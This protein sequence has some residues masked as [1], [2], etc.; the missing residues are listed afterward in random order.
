MSHRPI[1]FFLLGA[2]LFAEALYLVG[3]IPPIHG[4]LTKIFSSPEGALNLAPLMLNYFVLLLCSRP[5]RQ[6]VLAA[7]FFGTLSAGAYI[8]IV[9]PAYQQGLNY[10][11][12]WLGMNGLVCLLLFVYAARLGH[13]GERAKYAKLLSFSGL[14]V[15]YAL[16]AEIYLTVTSVMQPVT[17]DA[18]MYAFDSTFGFQPSQ[19]AGQLLKSGGKPFIIFGELAYKSL[20]MFLVAMY[21]MQIGSSSRQPYNA[22]KF[23]IVSGTA[24]LCVYHLF[25]VAGPRYLFTTQFFPDNLLPISE[26]GLEPLMVLPSPRN[27]MP[28]MHF[29]WAL[30]LWLMARFQSRRVKVVYSLLLAMTIFTTLGL[31]EH[32]L[33]DLVVA[34]PFVLALLSVCAD[35]LP[36]SDPRR[37]R[38]LL[39]GLG[40]YFA[41]LVALRFGL[42]LFLAV[43]GLSWLSTIFSTLICIPF[44]RQLQNAPTCSVDDLERAGSAASI[45]TE[46]QIRTDGERRYVGLLF[47]MSGAAALIYQVLFSKELSYVFGSQA[48]ATYT[49]L[50][51]Y[52]GGMAIGAWLGG[53]WAAGLTQPIR[54]YAICELAI[55]G[56]CLMSPAIFAG[57]QRLYQFLGTSALDQ[58]GILLGLRLML[59]GLGLLIP[60]ILMGM[61]LPILARHFERRS[62]TLG[63]SVSLLY[64]AN[65]LG[66]GFGALCAGYA[67]IPLLGIW[68][69]TLMTVAINLAVALLAL[70]LHKNAGATTVKEPDLCNAHV[71]GVDRDTFRRGLLALV[72]LTVGGFVTLSIEVDYVHLLAVV[73]GNSTYAFSLMLFSFL[74]G[75]GGGAEF[76]RRILARRIDRAQALA[77][78]ELCLALSIFAT[79]YAWDGIPRY[80][81]SFERYPIY[82]GFG[83]REVIRGAVCFLTMFPAAFFIGTIFP[84]AIEE[85]GAAFPKRQIA[86]LG[87]ASALNT[88]GNILGV[89]LTGFVLLPVLGVLKSNQV[90]AIICILL[91]LSIAVV[92][93]KLSRPYLF[94]SIV[95]V[96]SCYFLQPATLN[97]DLLSTGANV[98]FKKQDYGTVVAHAE[99]LDGGLTTANERRLESGQLVRTLLTNGK[100]QGNN[101]LSGEMQAQ[102]GFALATLTHTSKRDSAL[103]IGF[104]TGT[105]ARAFHAAG[106]RDLEIADL[107]SD[108]YNMSARYFREVNDGVL[109]KPSVTAHVIDGRNLLMLSDKKYDVISIEVTSIW[110]AGA[111]SLYNREFYQLAKRRLQS[112]G[113]LQQWMQLHHAT[114]LDM[115]YILS[116]IRSEFDYVWVYFL[117]GQAII[118]ASN[119]AAS[120]P[121]Q[122]KIRA[123][124][125]NDTPGLK[126]FTALFK[127]GAKSVNEG[128]LLPPTDVD[129]MLDSTGLPPEFF[130]STDDNLFLEYSTP[131]GNALDTLG[132]MQTNLGFLSRFRGK[133][134]P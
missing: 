71:S 27:G 16:C 15:L 122:G 10:V 48:V 36:W 94:S 124:D 117:G 55:G 78:L 58:P 76:G 53:K 33:I 25:P 127:E 65:T 20:A 44:Y 92:V 59:G 50:A 116:T 74:I 91:A 22:L 9:R 123:L 24:A 1:Y 104:G 41:W 54:A 98:Y 73:A 70:E 40:L 79:A 125:F 84:V 77:F 39:V 85:V 101:H 57:L 63:Y 30:A 43:P 28:S 5:R 67:I 34:I 111:A 23:L 45:Q 86:M 21:G 19:V 3:F 132:T 129:R 90:L 8:W 17:L 37:Y 14:L 83:A 6:T 47:F 133:T 112:D 109:E 2:F 11:D 26:V 61:T 68:K 88:M 46:E 56:Y 60:T 49:V 128:L 32:Y 66:A 105:T 96:I 107:S 12:L 103:V 108:I 64:G 81:G 134:L 35:T 72:V 106:F 115:L 13:V 89:L 119:D 126:P 52:M 62:A 7:L 69:T 102:A 97:Y 80:F 51:T 38:S 113:V 87:W 131:M 121:T 100:F 95:V 93:R 31:G 110:F 4:E 29:G 114:Q 75:L 118:I 99:S 130:V 120:G 18:M 82:F 42:K